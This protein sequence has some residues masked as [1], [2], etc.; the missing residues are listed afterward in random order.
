MRRY[1]PNPELRAFQALIRNE[2]QR[3]G[4]L[5]RGKG[6]VIYAIRDPSQRDLIRQHADGP[7]VYVGR[8]KQ[9][10]I[11]ANDHM[12]DGGGGSTDTGCKT[13]RL[14]QI[15]DKWQVPKFEILDTAPTHLTSLIAETIWARRFIWLGYEL[16]NQWAEHQTADRPNGLGSV[17]PD[18]LWDFTAAE[19]AEDEVRLVL[20]CRRCRIDADVNLSGLEPNLKLNKVRSQSIACECC[21]GRFVREVKL[22]D[23]RTWRWKDYSPAAMAPKG[24]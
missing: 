5:A 22:P 2:V 14:K 15:I 9:L 23:A 17:P 8:T 19:A 7:P 18:R 1:S 24:G 20:E 13:G 6:H 10:R 4:D 12:R 21:G 16:A 3:I 11:R